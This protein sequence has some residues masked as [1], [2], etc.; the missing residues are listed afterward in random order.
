MTKKNKKIDIVLLVLVAILAL[1]GLFI[2]TSASFG[3][4]A[5]KGFSLTDLLFDQVVLGLMLGCVVLVGAL[6]TPLKLIRKYAIHIFIISIYIITL[7]MF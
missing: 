3:L 4:L 5:R 1:G 2:F 7:K 6:Y